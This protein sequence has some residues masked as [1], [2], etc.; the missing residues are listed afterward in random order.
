M[1]PEPKRALVAYRMEQADDSMKMAKIAQEHGLFR[2]T[3]SRSYYAMFY[4]VLALMASRDQKTAKHTQTIGLF[5]LHF[6]KESLFDKHFSSWL[7]EAFDL[8]QRAD[9]REMVTITQQRAGEVLDHATQ[10]VA[11]VQAFLSRTL[12]K[13]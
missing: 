9:Y 5:D 11:E 13:E 7:H 3:V 1:I 6:V 2:D 12:P 8:R 10:F 4:A